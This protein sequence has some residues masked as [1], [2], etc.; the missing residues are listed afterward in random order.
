[1]DLTLFLAFLAATLVIIATPGPA[2]ALASSLA[3][4]HGP[5][6]AMASVAGDAL[7]SVVHIVVAV[8]SLSALLSVASQILP[9]L[10]IIGGLYI[11]YLAYS[12]F[13]AKPRAPEENAVH[14]GYRS[15]FISG[16]FSC[17]SNPKAIVFFAALF[18]SFIS[19]EH[20]VLSQSFIYGL[21]FVVLDGA[22]IMGYAML[23][24]AALRSPLG[25]RIN[26][27]KLSG[28]GLFGIGAFLIFKGYR[29]LRAV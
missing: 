21:I 18:P 8:L 7:G 29:D 12:A 1:M 10:Q 2:V 23:A 20:D 6:A 11:L 4:R 14:R 9:A 28:A 25:S 16:F 27:D 5:R 3:V 13:T 24:L 22:S 17:V 19:P 26:V 15:A